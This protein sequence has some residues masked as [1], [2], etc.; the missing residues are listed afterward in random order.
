MIYVIFP[1]PLDTI[2][3]VTEEGVRQLINKLKNIYI[4]QKR[5]PVIPWAGRHVGRETVRIED[6]YI[7]PE[8]LSIISG[9]DEWDQIFQTSDEEDTTGSSKGIVL[10]GRTGSGKTTLLLK[11][12]TDWVDGENNALK[13]CEAVFHVSLMNLDLDSNLGEAVVKHLLKDKQFSPRFIEHFIEDNQKEVAIL[14]DGYDEFKGKGLEQ[15]PCGNIV[16]MLRREYLPDVKLL[17]TTRPGRVHDFIELN[18]TSQVYQIFEVVGFSPL[19]IDNY[20]DN[21]FKQQPLIGNKLRD[22][23][24]ESH[25]KTDLACLPLMCC[26][27]CQLAKWTDG[28]DFKNISTTSSL[29]DELIEYLLEFHASS[30]VD[31]DERLFR[32]ED[33]TGDVRGSRR[34]KKSDQN[35]NNAFLLDLGKV[36]LNGFMK[37]EKEELKF[38]ERDFDTCGSKLKVIEWGCKNGILFREDESTTVIIRFTLKIFQENLAGRYLASLLSQRNNYFSLPGIQQI[39]EKRRV[40]SL[41][42]TISRQKI[43]DLKNVLLFACGTS[44]DA[45][46]V[47][48]GAVVKDLMSTSDDLELYQKGELH[49]LKLF[50]VIERIEICLQLNY[51]S[52]SLG[53]LNYTMKPLFDICKRLRLVETIPS[54]AKYIGYLM[55]YSENF[56]FE[57][58]E[59]IRIYLDSVFTVRSTLDTFY[60]LELQISESLHEGLEQCV[61]SKEFLREEDMMSTIHEH[62]IKG[63]KIPSYL[64]KM[65]PANSFNYI[66]CLWTK[67]KVKERRTISQ[68]IIRDILRGMRTCQITELTLSGLREENSDDWDNLFTIISSDYLR[69]LQKVALV[70]NGLKDVHMPTLLAA[71]NSLRGLTHLDLSGNNIGDKLIQLIPNHPLKDLKVLTLREIAMSSDTIELLGKCLFHFPSLQTLDIR[72]NTNMDDRGLSS[73]L[74]NLFHC[75]GLERLMLS[76]DKVTE[77]GFKIL[78]NSSISSLK[79]LHLLGTQFP[80]IALQCVSNILPRMTS[81]EELV[82]NQ[83]LQRESTSDPG[84]LISSDVARQFTDAICIHGILQTVRVHFIKFDAESFR[85]L[86]T[87]CIEPEVV[88]FW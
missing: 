33:E 67:F 19:D 4:L 3:E 83:R 30:E 14:L 71:L 68:G 21:A 59:I 58:L 46:R 48:I 23:L 79:E 62:L 38:T 43:L 70:N 51:E 28:K 76:L 45:A 16:K 88:K 82:I 13:G 22:F 50:G 12:L 8:I 87:K 36:A 75:P 69:A 25:L 74:T 5:I 41:L 2:K 61:K 6:V 60:G 77:I 26:A 53:K 40:N 66:V 54:I 65:V 44:V 18:K 63:N 78:E 55:E 72:V 9:Q 17:I 80:Q 37:S 49:F 42:K 7:H 27:F 24:E 73:I 84:D 29:L 86:L 52:Q 35:K 1:F 31:T 20:I 39:L 47:I 57:S 15:E 64:L 10:K 11:M 34:G 81:M 32:V 56:S 85:Y